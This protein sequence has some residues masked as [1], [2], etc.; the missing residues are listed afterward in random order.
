MRVRRTR[1]QWTN[2]WPL[3]REKKTKGRKRLH[4]MTMRIRLIVACKI[5]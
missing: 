4:T 3:V 1:T 5:S 2:H